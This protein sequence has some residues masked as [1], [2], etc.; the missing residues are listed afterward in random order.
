MFKEILKPSVARAKIR[1]SVDAPAPK[2]K[3][4]GQHFH[5]HYEL[6]YAQHGE[7]IFL[8]QGKEHRVLEGEIFFVGRQVPH[9]TK[10]PK[11]AHGVL[12][13]FDD[14][15]FAA[16]KGIYLPTP[17]GEAVAH[18]RPQD[19]CYRE[20]RECFE[21]IAAEHQSGAP[22][23]DLYLRAYTLQIEACLKREGILAQEE[24][25]GER[26]AAILPALSYI[27]EHFAESISL[28][29][30]AALLNVDKAHCCRLFKRALGMP[31]LQYLHRLRI[32][33]A[34]RLLAETDRSVGEIA[35][36]V[37]FCSAAYFAETFKKVYA[38]S[39]RE[40]RRLH[41]DRRI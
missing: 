12:L 9:G 29:Q 17:Q 40:H 8:A 22:A 39:P 16:E 30:V 10:T 11:G 13:Q 20:L 3:E 4:F 35:D 26:I 2:E 27:N 34:E 7:R 25:S 5:R 14:Q 37:G 38:H 18:F 31:F 41:T 6:F 1:V 32:H 28:E 21:R 19:R 23:A 15:S 24:Q 33:R 36:Q